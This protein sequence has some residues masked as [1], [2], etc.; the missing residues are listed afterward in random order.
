MMNNLKWNPGDYP[1]DQQ[2]WTDKDLAKFVIIAFVAG[3]FIGW[4]F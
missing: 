2:L 4:L 1:Y 3:V